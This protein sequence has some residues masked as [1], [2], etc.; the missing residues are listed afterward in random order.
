MLQPEK[1]NNDIFAIQQ[2][3]ERTF[4]EWFSGIENFAVDAVDWVTSRPSAVRDAGDSL[5]DQL[6]SAVQ[7]IKG[8][9]TETA[10]GNLIT[11]RAQRIGS[12]VGAWLTRGNNIFIAGAAL[13]IIIFYLWRK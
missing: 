13:A 6:L 7:R 4:S 5:E 1:T 2:P 11:S 10:K 12:K 9:A 3:R 8:D